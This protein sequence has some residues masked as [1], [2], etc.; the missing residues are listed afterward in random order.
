MNEEPVFKNHKERQRY[1]E[2]KY[3]NR[4]KTIHVSIMY[5]KDGKVIQPGRTYTKKDIFSNGRTTR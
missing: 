4:G 2:E 3:K 1:Y 5:D